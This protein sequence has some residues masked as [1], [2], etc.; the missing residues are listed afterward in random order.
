MTTDSGSDER[1]SDPAT[2]RLESHARL[3]RELVQ[4]AASGETD[5]AAGPREIDPAIYTDSARFEIE[6]QAFRKLPI[7]ACLSG[8][9]PGPASKLLVDTLGPE[10]VL[11]RTQSGRVR[12]FLN[13]CPHRAAR[14]VTE[15]DTRARMTCHFHGWTFD[16]DG[17]LVGLPGQ[18][19]FEGVDRAARGLA[20][21]A[22]AEWHGLVFVRV[23]PG[24]PIDVA[25]HL[26]TFGEELRHLDLARARPIKY[27]RLETRANWKYSWDTY[28]ESYHFGTLH[29]ST[30]APR[31]LSNIAVVKPFGRHAR[32]GFPRREWAEYGSRPESDWPPVDYG[33]NYFIY[34]NI[35]V[36][37]SC[38]P[39]GEMF[40]GFYH[41]YPGSQVDHTVT[42]MMTYRP[43]HADEAYPDS[44]WSSL[45]DFVETVVRTE[46]Y[47]VAEEGQRNLATL[48]AGWTLLFGANEILPQKWH[49]D[50]DA[51]LSELGLT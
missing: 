20:E 48:P 28:C 44:D 11:V 21:I 1:L 32:T 23:A 31:V 29:A 10:I 35:N 41:L 19:G 26:G 50:W 40:Y 18:A 14:V 24:P 42:R 8:D 30:V 9:L 16:L 38:G 37:V 2:T 47:A 5:L 27:T 17:R 6:R 33:G 12:A 7:L 25:A 49:A 15:C 13:I 4:R 34:P 46:D 39:N 22:A 51:T 3:R 36:N 45:H 43:A